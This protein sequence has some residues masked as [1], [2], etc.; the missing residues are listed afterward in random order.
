VDSRK[1]TV[2]EAYVRG[3]Q[4]MRDLLAM[5]LEIAL[6][7]SAAD[8]CRAISAFAYAPPKRN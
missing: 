7:K 5:C 2:P 3:Q 6:D 4:E 1:E 8:K